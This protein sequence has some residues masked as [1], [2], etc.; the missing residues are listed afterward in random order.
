[1]AKSIDELTQDMQHDV[2]LTVR[3][4]TPEDRQAYLDSLPDVAEKA[5]T[6]DN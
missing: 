1:M 4:T 2:R 5:A 3:L 6:S